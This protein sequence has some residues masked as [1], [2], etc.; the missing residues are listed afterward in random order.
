MTNTAFKKI[1]GIDSEEMNEFV[2]TNHGSV[3]TH[4]YMI[5]LEGAKKFCNKP[6][7]F[8]IDTQLLA[9][10]KTYNYTAYAVNNNMVETSQDNSTLSDS[11]PVLLNS[12]LKHIHLNNLKTPS[13]LDWVANENFFKLGPFNIN[14]LI[15]ALI[16]I[17]SIMP[18]K[19]YMVILLWL[20]T[21]FLISFD[22]KNTLRFLV[23][24]GIPMGIKILIQPLKR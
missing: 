19:Y 13:T 6:I 2:Q 20:L 5:S 22:I 11:Y 15:V 24:L 1:A 14:F 7:N 8:H 21:E 18:S 17:I 10:I 16:F 9:W 12:M 23:L 3:G 4:A